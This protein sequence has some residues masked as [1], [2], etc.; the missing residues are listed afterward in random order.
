MEDISDD[1][2][3]Q[4]GNPEDVPEFEGEPPAKQRKVII[5]FSSWK[6]NS[7]YFSECCSTSFVRKSDETDWWAEKV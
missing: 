5:L 6:V 3:D 4:P 2:D 7:F 1:N